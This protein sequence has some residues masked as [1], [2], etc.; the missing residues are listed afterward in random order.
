MHLVNR[1]VADLAPVDP[2]DTRDRWQWVSRARAT[3]ASSRE[4]KRAETDPSVYITVPHQI[5]HAG[6]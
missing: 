6:C 5:E 2:A 4:Q 3:A 1:R